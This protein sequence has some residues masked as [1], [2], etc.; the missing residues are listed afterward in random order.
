MAPSIPDPG[1]DVTAPLTIPARPELTGGRRIGVLLSHGFTGSPASM[2]PWGE[3]LGALG[4]G[5]AVPLLPGHGTTWRE[6]NTRRWSDWYAALTRAFEALRAEH[7][8]VV[9]GGLSMGGALVLRLAADRPDEVAGVMLVNPAIATR[10]LDVRL[11]PVLKH[12]VASFPAIANDIKKP[13]VDERGY[14]RTPLKAIHSL[15]QAWPSLRSD[16]ARIT[17][18]LIYFRSAEDHVVDDSSEPLVLDGVSS[19]DVTRVALP[20][21]FHVATLDHD[22]PLIFEQSSAFVARVTGVA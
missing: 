22:A 15:L 6:L 17:A 10:R 4:Y 21:S 11:L 5:V 18:P 9:V 20:E 12:V 1:T 19:T 7:D 3:H 2:R 16:L 13:G 14:D 8:A